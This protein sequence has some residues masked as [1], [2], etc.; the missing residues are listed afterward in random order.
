MLGTLALRVA[1]GI[2][3]PALGPIQGYKVQHLFITWGRLKRF[4]KKFLPSLLV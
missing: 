3:F 4:F 2:L 1:N